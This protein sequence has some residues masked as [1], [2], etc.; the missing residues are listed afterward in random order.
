M[1]WTLW[2]VDKV[3]LIIFV[4]VL[5]RMTAGMI[6]GTIMWG[7]AY[8]MEQIKAG[9]AMGKTPTIKQAIGLFAWE[10]IP[11]LAKKF[12]QYIESWGKGDGQT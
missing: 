2:I 3:F 4:L 6:K 8:V 5:M 11:S 9:K 12:G 10:V 7:F 1:D